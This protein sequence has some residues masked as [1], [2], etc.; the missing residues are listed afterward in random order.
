MNHW[1]PL[2]WR[3]RPIKQDPGYPDAARLAPVTDELGQCPPLVLAGE[4]RALKAKL[5]EVAARKAFLVQGGDCAESF[6]EFHANAIRDLYQLLLELAL[7]VAQAGK[8]VVLVGRVAGQ[9]AKPRSAATEQINGLELPSYRGDIVNG[10][11]FSAD[12][13]RPDPLRMLKAYHQAAATLNLIR[14][15]A[16]SDFAGNEPLQFRHV[17]YR[18]AL[19]AQVSGNEAASI[20][21]S[22]AP[23]LF[24]SHEALLLPYEQALTRRDSATGLWYN[25][26]AHMLW[27]GDRTRDSEDAH[28]EFCRGIE[29]P[30]GIKCGPSMTPDQLLR[31]LCALDPRREPG[32]ITL[33]VRMGAGAVLSR[34]APLIA[35]VRREGHPVI[36]SCDPMHG[37]TVKASNGYK[38]R[39]FQTIC[40]ELEEFFTVQ[41]A[42]GACADGIHLEMTGKNVTECTGGMQAIDDEGLRSR[43]HSHCDPRLNGLQSAELGRRLAQLIAN[44]ASRVDPEF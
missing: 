38:T 39:D 31:L 17:Q 18:S 10:A 14:A 7:V 13:R 15:L 41:Q 12:A 33:I 24:T 32:R 34:L 5:A 35:A 30:I 6:S 3:G 36:W 37:N 19:G 21:W 8:P 27:I 42:L 2:T 40:A 25:C 20:P 1:T 22:S 44:A 43:Y 11:A 9:F 26:S 23:Q 16:Q 4:I 29:N 28:V